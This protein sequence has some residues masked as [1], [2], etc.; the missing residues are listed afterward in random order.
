MDGWMDV[1]VHVLDTVAG[2]CDLASF[3]TLLLRSFAAR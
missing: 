3:D 1:Y 2:Y